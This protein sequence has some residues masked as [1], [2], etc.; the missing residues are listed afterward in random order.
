MHPLCLNWVYT[1]F[2][3]AT[4]RKGPK[5]TIETMPLT[6][7][8][9]AQTPPLGILWSVFWCQSDRVIVTDDRGCGKPSTMHLSRY[10]QSAAGSGFLSCCRFY[11]AQPA[12]E[13]DC[14]SKRGARLLDKLTQLPPRTRLDRSARNRQTCGACYL[15]HKHNT[16]RASCQ[17]AGTLWNARLCKTATRAPS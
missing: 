11:S 17:A 16:R 15:F 12:L 2:F 3:S 14:C 4:K 5:C 10:S 6:R 1:D 7:K 13:I 9:G 8:N